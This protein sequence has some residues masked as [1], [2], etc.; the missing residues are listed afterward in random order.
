MR[1]PEGELLEYIALLEPTFLTG[2]SD[3]KVSLETLGVVKV[4]VLKGQIWGS[5]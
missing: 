3:F 5:A 1:Y 2:Y 4:L